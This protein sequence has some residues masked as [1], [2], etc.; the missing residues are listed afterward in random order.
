MVKRQLADIYFLYV[1]I[2]SDCHHIIVCIC[3]IN[4]P[5]VPR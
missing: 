1:I 3:K 4:T 2:F 5:W